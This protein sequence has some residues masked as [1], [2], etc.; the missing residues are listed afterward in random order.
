MWPTELN[1]ETKMLVLRSCSHCM[2]F[3][4]E[5]RLNGVY[6]GSKRVQVSESLKMKQAFRLF[7]HL[8]MVLLQNLELHRLY[9]NT[10]TIYSKSLSS[11]VTH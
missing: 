2:V 11:I 9:S 10:I 7:K 6:S 1:T 3:I 5:Q 4:L 8:Q